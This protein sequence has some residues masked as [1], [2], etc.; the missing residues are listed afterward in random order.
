MTS[1]KVSL[2]TILI[3]ACF[4]MLIFLALFHASFSVRSDLEHE[5]VPHHRDATLLVEQ[6][7]KELNSLKSISSSI[8]KDISSYNSG[9]S[10][11][12]VGTQV[13]AV[14]TQAPV[15]VRVSAQ[16]PPQPQTLTA[17]NPPRQAPKM[18][19]AGTLPSTLPSMSFSVS[20]GGTDWSAGDGGG[21]M[22]VVGGTDGSGSRRVVSLLVALG[23]PMV[24]EDPETYDIHADLVGGWPKMVTPLLRVSVDRD[25]CLVL[26]VEIMTDIVLFCTM[27][28]YCTVG[29]PIVE[30]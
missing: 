11:K 17:P 2:K 16:P 30:I 23:V 21:S 8:E 25:R 5:T 27:N 6:M 12:A 1:L 3:F 24:S 9:M 7:R 29:Y 22:L 26:D 19:N 18:H 10:A 15:V 13:Q 20:S 4:I 14:Q 28:V